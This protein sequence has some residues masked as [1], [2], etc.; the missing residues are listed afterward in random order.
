[1]KIAY[2]TINSANY[3]P[4]AMVLLDSIRK[5][6]SKCDLHM[7]LAENDETCNRVTPIDGITLHRAS[8]LEIPTLFD[9]SFYYNITEF[10]T[11]L[12]PFAILKL[13]QLGYDAVIYFDPDIEIFSDTIEL[14]EM[15]ALHDLLLTPHIT[16]PR[17]EDGFFPPV[18]LCIHAGQFNLGFIAIRPTLQATEFLHW[19]ADKLVEGCIMEPDYSYFVDQLW[20]SAGPSF[21][22]D[23]KIVRSDAWN[24]AYWN[25]GQRKLWCREKQWMTDDGPLLFFHFSG[26][27]L[28]DP[29]RLS[30]FTER[31]ANVPPNSE[32]GS[33]LAGY[34][35][36]VAAKTIL[37]PYGNIPYSAGKYRDGSII[38]P[39]ARRRYLQMTPSERVTLGDPF[40]RPDKLETATN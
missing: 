33:L 29:H 11:A 36:T 32:L 15:T 19:W 10:N 40:V 28:E 25:I 23:T 13:M 12:K 24:M 18:R 31:H 6:G 7:V 16:K 37:Y 30:Y 22:D 14:E 39:V 38:S 20:A 5:N 4:R 2:M 35:G 17:K 8:S 3:I 27:D 9:M 26:Y 1:M 34:R 21:V